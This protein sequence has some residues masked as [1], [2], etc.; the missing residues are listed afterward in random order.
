MADLITI[1]ASYVP[2]LVVR[3]LLNDPSPATTSLENRFPAA[4]LFADLSGFTVLTEQLAQQGPEGAEQLS[5]FLNKTFDGLIQHITA[6]GGDVVTFAGDALLAL[7]PATDTDLDVMTRRAAQC[8]LVLQELLHHERLAT[9]DCLN[10]RIGIAS[11]EVRMLHVGGVY[12]RWLWLVTGNPVVD[13]M[14]AF[15]QALPGEVVVAPDAWGLVAMHCRG[16]PVTV[17]R[18]NPYAEESVAY[19]RTENGKETHNHLLEPSPCVCESEERFAVSL[20]RSAPSLPAP[21]QHLGSL[22]TDAALPTSVTLSL[23]Q[24]SMPSPLAKGNVSHSVA[25][26]DASG[27]ILDEVLEPLPQAYVPPWKIGPSMEMLLRAYIPDVVLTRLAAGQ[28]SWLAELRIVTVLF[29]NLPDVS[30]TAAS[31]ERIQR[32]IRALQRALYRYEGS[33]NKLSVDE[34]GAILIAVFG[35]PPLAH[36]DDAIR[37]VQ[38]A[39]AIKEYLNASG[40]QCAIGVTTGRAF[41]GVVGNDQR[42]EYTILGDTVNLA[43]RLMQTTSDDILC[44]TTT[45]QA[46]HTRLVFDTLP[47]I[48]VKGKAEPVQIYCPRGEAHASIHPQNEIIGR[49]R[50]RTILASQLQMLRRTTDSSTHTEAS[51]I[52]LEGDAGN[53]KS[54]LIADLQVHGGM[55]GIPTFVGAADST[56]QTTPYYAWRRVFGD[57]LELDKAQDAYARQ[58][59]VIEL[60]AAEPGML[61]DVSL[62]NIVIPIDFAQSDNTAKLSGQTLADSTRS[63]LRDVLQVLLGRTPTLLIIDDAHWLD[64]ASW[65]LLVEVCKYMPYLLLVIATRPL[66]DP[67]PSEYEHL[68]QLPYTQRVIVEPLSL[69]ETYELVCQRLGAARAPESITNLIYEKAQ[70]NPFYTEEMAY[71]LRESEQVI[72]QDGVCWVAPNT[73][74]LQ[75][76][77]LPDTVHGVITSRIDR[78]TPAQQLTLK[79]ASVIGR[80]FS[81]HVLAAIYPVKDEV[82]ALA[83][84]LNTL[85]HLG[86]IQHDLA[87]PGH[88]YQFKNVIT[89]EVVYD[90]MPFAQRRQ[91]H[92]AVAEWYIEALPEYVDEYAT[93]LAQHFAQ[94]D[95]RRAQQYYTLA[96]NEAFRIYAN[97]EAIAHFTHALEIAKK[98][99][100]CT[101]RFLYLYTQLGHI[102][103]LQGEY[104]E[105]LHTYEQMEHLADERNNRE[106]KLVALMA[107]A[108]LRS[109]PNP[110]FDPQRGETLLEQALT[111]ARTMHDRMAESKILWNLMLLKVY[112][113]D[114]AHQAIAYGEQS[115]KLARVFRQNE[116]IAFTLNDLAMAYRNSG[117]LERSQ[118]L[119]EEA[120]VHWRKLNNLPMLIENLSRYAFGHFL[121][122]N[123]DRALASSKEAYE[124][125]QSIGSVA[126][127][128][129]SQFMMGYVYFERGQ[130]G[131]AIE[132]MREVIYLGEQVGDLAIQICTRADLGLI[133]GYLGAVDDGIVLT[134]LAYARSEEHNSIFRSWVMA[135]LAR[136]HILNG[137]L[138]EAHHAVADSYQSLMEKNETSLT[139]VYVYLADAELAQERHAH[140]KVLEIADTI[141]EY[142]TS[143]QIRPF[144][145]D[146]LYLKSRALLALGQ[147][148]SARLLLQEARVEAEAIGSKRILWQILFL[149]SHV[150]MQ[151]GYVEAASTMRQRACVLV[152]TIADHAGTAELRELFL[153]HPHVLVVAR[154]LCEGHLSPYPMFPW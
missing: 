12:E 60:L 141:L 133:Y 122:G 109:T 118:A 22:C 39:L 21:E 85:V 150:E 50:E 70:G 35:L 17:H 47:P 20:C 128:A 105:A 23:L 57:L 75:A 52:V 123:Y 66:S 29:V 4:I 13:V 98:H 142:L 115:L 27:M 51:V 99:A 44:D 74:E 16:R 11:G 32:G 106:I 124:L 112:A 56:E 95:D 87:K 19:Q 5:S 153:M 137:N 79:V 18:E 6:L 46:A 119:L 110:T 34:K 83:D 48:Q 147:M 49:T 125:S 64:S 96:G 69:D 127:K 77:R 9:H 90:L 92:R 100:A 121:A 145:P 37:G 26:S 126:G 10:V 28:E 93:L 116:Q 31:L 55:L 68:F 131:M 120:C 78:L 148:D 111:L 97:T 76:L 7:W 82:H 65:S 25:T 146:T 101:E 140:K 135:T 61:R 94:A 84:N 72:I 1:L 43:A 36:E 129:K 41:C 113:G 14:Q 67:L 45:F 24:T 151:M 54:R 139:P 138:T 144:R 53:G 2:A 103:E 143:H 149:L 59:R 104:D 73:N 89:Q 152:N 81:Y 38:A 62:L 130:P 134:E 33:V 132:I 136:L 8:A 15:Q 86:L 71:A 58:Q 40:M 154:P 42:R 114:N 88:G 91:L 3:R 108:K 80:A 117:Q 107:L 102:F 30:N 63:Y